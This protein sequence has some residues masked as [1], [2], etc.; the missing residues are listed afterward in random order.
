MKKFLNYFKVVYP[1]MF[2]MFVG[3]SST[4]AVTTL[5]LLIDPD[6]NVNVAGVQ[7]CTAT[8]VFL[9]ATST[10]PILE[11]VVQFQFSD[12]GFVT[13]IRIL[14]SG[15][16]VGFDLGT[17]PTTGCRSYRVLYSTFGVPIT[18]TFTNTVQVCAIPDKGMLTVAAPPTVCQDAP[19]TVISATASNA[20]NIMLTAT[21]G[22]GAFLLP[23]A[24]LSANLTATNSFD[25]NA[26]FTGPITFTAT[27]DGCSAGNF[28]VGA[29]TATA[30]TN[31]L[32]AINPALTV[33]I[34]PTVVCQ[35]QTATFTATN[36]TANGGFTFGLSNPLL[37]TLGNGTTGVVV[38]ATTS[39]NNVTF[40]G[41]GTVQLNVGVNGCVDPAGPNN[42]ALGTVAAPP[43]NI[44]I[45]Q[46]PILT[47]ITVGGVN[48]SCAGTC[49]PLT[50]T[51][52][53]VNGFAGIKT[54]V[55]SSST[56]P[57]ITVNIPA[58]VATYDVPGL[59]CPTATTTY[60]V[61]SV[62]A[63][64]PLNICS[65]TQG[66][67][68][69]ATA[70]VTPITA[71][72]AIPITVSPSAT[73]CQGQNVTLT[74]N[75]VG[76][77][78][79]FSLLRGGVT[80][81]G[82]TANNTFIIPGNVANSGQY[83]VLVQGTCGGP[84]LSAPITVTITSPSVGGTI[85]PTPIN[86]CGIGT[87]TLTLTG[88][89][90]VVLGWEMQPNCTGPFTPIAGT[91]GLT[92]IVVTAPAGTTCYRAVVQNGIC[93]AANSSV[94]T[95]NVDVPAVGGFVRNNMNATSATICPGQ[96][97][98]LTVVGFTGKVQKWQVNNANTGFF[99]DIPGTA[100]QTSI[101]VAGS[102]VM[103]TNFYR[104]VICSALG[105]CTGPSAVAF[106]APFRLVRGF[107][108]LNPDGS[109]ANQEVAE[110]KTAITKAYPTPTSHRVTLDIQGAAEGL[111]TIE[112]VDLIGRVVKS[113]KTELFSGANQ[114]S[115]DISELASGIYIV[116]F[117][118]KENHRASMKI[119]RQ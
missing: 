78:L 20:T 71:F 8:P 36:P 106:S 50:L 91:A 87:N 53:I 22:A 92:S 101:T 81:Q 63:S 102:S 62:A 90:G 111:A 72:A 7:I 99:V 15:G 103:G 19:T 74:A 84:I 98:V 11:S 12:D 17:K 117:T 79:L 64:D 29:M 85:A 6:I 56:G 69:S 35:G 104:A 67:G 16:N 66:I 9:L 30:I 54:V 10:N 93:P 41:A 68:L 61:L 34:G 23:A 115:V 26:A 5:S 75:A 112:V 21:A 94:V 89:T 3:M 38:N 45:N 13:D 32:P 76:S 80:I 48:P 4:K 55:L 49:R 40:T 110:E 73:V 47:A 27:A 96:N 86:R 57:N 37:A 14:P 95:I 116:K 59:A 118:D 77:G 105:I 60:T 83:Q 46:L 28:V 82:P 109:I 119:T 2:F 52:D 33:I 18:F 114:V 39:T 113:Q 97:I 65:G 107:F 51:F 88:Q 108:C 44:T 70:T 100:G 42:G 25:F 43:F 31:V 24:T 1:L 58:G